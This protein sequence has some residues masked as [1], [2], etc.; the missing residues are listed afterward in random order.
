MLLGDAESWQK[1]KEKMEAIKSEDVEIEEP[2]VK[3]TL[4]NIPFII[5]VLYPD[6]TEDEF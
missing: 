1:R 4:S 2:R 5:R 6:M 3:S